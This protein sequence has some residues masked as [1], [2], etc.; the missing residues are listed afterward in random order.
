MRR[1]KK[2][3]AEPELDCVC[4]LQSSQAL[5]GRPCPHYTMAAPLS[6]WFLDGRAHRGCTVKA[7]TMRT[8]RAGLFQG[9]GTASVQCRRS[10]RRQNWP[11]CAGSA[12]L[13]CGNSPGDEPWW[14]S[15]RALLG[16]H[17]HF[18]PMNTQDLLDKNVLLKTALDEER[19][20]HDRSKTLKS[21]WGLHR[22]RWLEFCFPDLMHLVKQQ[23]RNSWKSSA[24]IWNQRL[25]LPRM[26]YGLSI[27]RCWFCNRNLRTRRPTVIDKGGSFRR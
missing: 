9:R 19:A 27:L 18:A 7:V 5:T 25:P 11:R 12:G 20:H 16:R 14:V 15:P 10:T 13:S 4:P 24:R 1:L 6:P 22:L 2:A 3:I 26:R 21:I 17:R 23:A 8:C